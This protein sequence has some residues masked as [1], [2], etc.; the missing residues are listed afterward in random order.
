MSTV[1]VRRQGGAAIVTIPTDVLKKLDIHIG[2]ELELSVEKESLIVHP[3]RV[4]Q[5]K[6]KKYTLKELL[7]GVTP[8]KMKLLKKET[9]WVEEGEAVGR[10]IE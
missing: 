10:E 9:E 6:R 1:T 2:S 8:E 4:K 3:I 5:S 7:Q